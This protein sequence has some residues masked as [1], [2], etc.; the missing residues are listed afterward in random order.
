MAFGILTTSQKET[1][2]NIDTKCYVCILDDSSNVCKDLA[3]I[4]TQIKAMSVLLVTG[5][6]PGSAGMNTLSGKHIFN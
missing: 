5:F 2:S 4:H 6:L 1:Y 3:D